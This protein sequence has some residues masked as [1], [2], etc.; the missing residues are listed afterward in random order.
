SPFVYSPP[1]THAVPPDTSVDPPVAPTPSFATPFSRSFGPRT[2]NQSSAAGI[3]T[4]STRRKSLG[5]RK[6]SSSEVDL[7]AADTFFIKVL[8]DDDFDDSDGETNPH[9]WH[10]FAAWELV[11]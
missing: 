11:P 5:S 6:M 10:A 2:R 1:S 4:Y 8:C 9:Y 7:N 3:R